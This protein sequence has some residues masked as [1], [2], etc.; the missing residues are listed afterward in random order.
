MQPM[1]NICNDLK[2]KHTPH[3][4]K[5]ALNPY[6]IK[7][8]FDRKWMQDKWENGLK[9]FLFSCDNIKIS[10]CPEEGKLYAFHPKLLFKDLF[11]LWSTLGNFLNCQKLF[12]TKNYD[13]CK[14][15]PREIMNHNKGTLWTEAFVFWKITHH[16]NC[17]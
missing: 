10:Y 13:H 14:R 11:Y 6:L 15:E 2:L 1:N 12:P 9:V 8:I 16:R 4:N 5:K 17:I 7:N 3:E